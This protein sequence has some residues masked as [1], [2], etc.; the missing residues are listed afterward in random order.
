MIDHELVTPRDL[1][2]PAE[3]RT[4][5]PLLVGQF[6]SPPSSNISANLCFALS[7]SGPPSLA[8]RWCRS[9]RL[10]PV[11]QRTGCSGRRSMLWSVS[12]QQRRMRLP[13]LRR[14]EKH[15]TSWRTKR[16]H[17]AFHN[18][19]GPSIRKAVAGMSVFDLD[20]LVA[21]LHEI[22]E[23]VQWLACGDNIIS[24]WCF[25]IEEHAK[26]SAPFAFICRVRGD[27]R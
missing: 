27:G 9:T 12:N 10:W 17:S 2:E 25:Y 4:L 23:Q 7:T 5:W 1:S 18:R 24:S 6:I 21:R 15:V 8:T 19:A 13:S 20:G 26:E 16:R 11:F 14:R 3:P 22:R